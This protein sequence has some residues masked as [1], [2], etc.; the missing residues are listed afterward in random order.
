MKK[1]VIIKDFIYFVAVV[2]LAFLIKE[3][4]LTPITV[5]DI[6][7][8]PTIQEG[9]IMILNRVQY[10]LVDVLRFEFVVVDE[11]GTNLIKRV[12]GL[13]GETVE[14]KD[15]KLYIGNLVYKED[16]LEAGVTTNNMG[17]YTLGEDEYFVMGDNRQNSFDSEEFGPVTKSQI[18]GRANIIIYPFNRMKA[19]R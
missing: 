9:D 19:M 13:P 4:F 7:S 14:Y 17:P 3:F 8:Y 2:I 6:S 15:N 11:D 5:H 12:V 18:Q 10:E 1:E 16:F